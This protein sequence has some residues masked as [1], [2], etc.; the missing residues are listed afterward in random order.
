MGIESS[1][2][3]VD[4]FGGTLGTEKSMIARDLVLSVNTG[5][6]NIII[7][8]VSSGAY[9]ST[10]SEARDS[11]KTNFPNLV[12]GEARDILVEM[13][14]PETVANDKYLLLKSKVDYRKVYRSD[15]NDD[16]GF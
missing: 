3:V 13:N 1:S 6:P 14:L 2:V 15:E 11:S 12:I 8:K 4:A 5:E 16:I 9:K 10:I 7:K